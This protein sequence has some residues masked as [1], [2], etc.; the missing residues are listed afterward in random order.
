MRCQLLWRPPRAWCTHQ[1][2]I[3]KVIHD[4]SNPFA[5]EV[6]CKCI[7]HGC[8]YLRSWVKPWD[9]EVFVIGWT[10][11][12]RYASLRSI[13]TSSALRPRLEIRLI[14]SSSEA[15]VSAHTCGLMLSLTFPPEG[16]D[17]SKI[18]LHFPS[19]DFG[20][21]PR[22][23]QW[24]ARDHTGH[25]GPTTWPRDVSAPM[26]ECST[27]GFSSDDGWFLWLALRRALLQL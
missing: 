7:C 1:K 10:G 3:I 23:L 12:M 13:L 17:R 9:G 15:C 8:E 21:K 24:T 19:Y 6:L 27:D 11:T 14:L 25:R 22:G 20:T 26:L 5:V 2:K 4:I 16:E 18:F